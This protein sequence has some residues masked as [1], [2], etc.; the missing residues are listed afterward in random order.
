MQ[1]MTDTKTG[2]APRIASCACNGLTLA[3]TGDPASVYACGCLNCQRGTGSAFAWRARF[4]KA[5]I[6]IEGERRSWR[7]TNEAGQWMEQTFC[8]TCGTLLFMSAEAMPDHVVVSAGCFADPAFAAPATFYFSRH[9][10]AWYAIDEGVR[11][12]E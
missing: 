1:P 12:V 10:P 5:A 7:R 4:A 6:R 8:P 9:R 2:T 11:M 3:A